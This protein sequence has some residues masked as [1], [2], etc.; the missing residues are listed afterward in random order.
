M[1]YAIFK[2]IQLLNW[3]S[4]L[5]AVLPHSIEPKIVVVLYT[6]VQVAGSNN[7]ACMYN[8]ILMPS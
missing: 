1:E 5:L 8:S 2:I 7:V 3:Y 4:K 6:T